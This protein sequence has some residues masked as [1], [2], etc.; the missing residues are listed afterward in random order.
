M[1]RKKLMESVNRF[2]KHLRLFEFQFR[3][4]RSHLRF[5]CMKDALGFTRQN[6]RNSPYVCPIPPYECSPVGAIVHCFDFRGAWSTKPQMCI[7]TGPPVPL[8]CRT[9]GNNAAEFPKDFFEC[10][11]GLKRPEIHS[12][13]LG[14]DC[15]FSDIEY[16]GQFC[17][18]CNAQIQRAFIIFGYDIVLRA[19]LPYELC[20]KYQCVKFAVGFYRSYVFYL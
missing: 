18:L 9:I 3:A 2:F 20:L 7:K 19:V 1:L 6:I 12:V 4:A 17:S 16:S 15:C 8:L 5:Q 11:A 10:F 13:P 14:V